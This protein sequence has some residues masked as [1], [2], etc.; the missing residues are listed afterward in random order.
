MVVADLVAAM[1]TS[2][3]ACT[4]WTKFTFW[5]QRQRGIFAFAVL[6]GALRLQVQ[7]LEQKWYF[8]ALLY[9]RYL[10]GARY[11]FFVVALLYHIDY[12]LFGTIVTGVFLALRRKYLQRKK[13]EQGFEATS[14]LRMA[15]FF[16]LLSY[17]VRAGG[18]I[19]GLAS[20]G[21]SY[22]PGR[23]L[24][25]PIADLLRIIS[26]M[27]RI[28][29]VPAAAAPHAGLGA[30]GAPGA[31]PLPADADDLHVFELF[32]QARDKFIEVCRKYKTQIAWFLLAVLIGIF[33]FVIIYCPEKLKQW[34]GDQWSSKPK[35][36]SFDDSEPPKI[37]AA[38]MPK[39]VM[40]V[41][42]LESTEVL[43]ADPASIATSAQ[44]YA[45]LNNVGLESACKNAFKADEQID[46][47]L[48][49]LKS[50]LT[51]VAGRLTAVEVATCETLADFEGGKRGN[52]GQNKK[53][54]AAGKGFKRS[55]RYVVYEKDVE[56]ILQ[57]VMIH[58]SERVPA[59]A[60]ELT[61]GDWYWKQRDSKGNTVIKALHIMSENDDQSDA[62]D[63][64]GRDD[65]HVSRG[66]YTDD[67]Y[68]DMEALLSP[69]APKKG[70]TVILT[71]DNLRSD[72]PKGKSPMGGK[73]EDKFEALVPQS[74]RWDVTHVKN[75]MG[76]VVRK[77]N[78]DVY[79]ELANCCSTWC[80]V[81]VNNHSLAN[82]THF[83]FGD[84][85][86]PKTKV[87][88]TLKTNTDLVVCMRVA[89][90]G[91]HG[92]KA[93]R[94]EKPVVGQKVKVV[95][96][97]GI[98]SEGVIQSVSEEGA[99]GLQMRVTNSTDEGDCGAAY[100]NV[101]GSIVGFH[102]KKGAKDLNNLA[103]PVTDEFLQLQPKN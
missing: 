99:Q 45:R 100:V 77:T 98:D 62:D 89:D 92:L 53:N 8:R 40:Q 32:F 85:Y 71:A 1:V 64:N 76:K 31:G 75:V 72:A 43:L 5:C 24:N 3:V 52:R 58:N 63:D 88:H 23:E 87:S 57:G 9:P 14:D 94:F 60:G 30:L 16:A 15:D 68:G 42:T 25:A 65:R 10:L 21:A 48:A 49:E 78:Q 47:T 44:A 103:V 46:R 26:D 54:R 22:I 29:V 50:L 28:N 4:L 74:V 69:V 84:K 34:F 39:S 82:A 96:E 73:G 59:K 86:F 55:K 83:K 33:L 35:P 80:G 41:G 90:G 17:G 37:T 102:F 13:E 81:V 12:V 11:A 67:P 61:A 101:N 38:V 51:D 93:R 66:R 2:F 36:L 18:I 91:P 95:R 27:F 20:F 79:E 56:D 19:A 70:P 97:D 6:P 7:H